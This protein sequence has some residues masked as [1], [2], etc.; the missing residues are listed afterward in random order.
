MCPLIF[1]KS[2]PLEPCS[3]LTENFESSCTQVYNYHRLLS[4]DNERGLHVDIFKVPTCCSCHLV[5]YKE[6]F[7]PLSQPSNSLTN[8]NTRK[9]VNN[10]DSFSS[11]STNKDL[12]YSTL[13]SDDFDEEDDSNIAYQFGNGFQRVK[14]KREKEKDRRRKPSFPETYLTPPSNGQ[15]LISFSNRPRQ[16]TPTI[17]RKQFDQRDA[18]VHETDLKIARVTVSPPKFSQANRPRKVTPPISSSVDSRINIRLPNAATDRKRIN[19]NYHPI[20]DF[21]EDDEDESM[22]RT[23]ERKTGKFADHHDDDQE[24]NWRPVVG[25][26]F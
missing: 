19:Y 6:A 3:Y 15:S 16:R 10:F 18:S 25:G 8:S 9:G 22:A 23:A 4:W 13:G 5:G 1:P 17:K 12:H 7:P 26:K 24:E 11:A 20:I 14:P 2:Q 21:F